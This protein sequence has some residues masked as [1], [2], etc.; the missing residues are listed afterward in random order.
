MQALGALHCL[1]ALE[2]NC[3]AGLGRAGAQAGCEPLA[4]LGQQLTALDLSRCSEAGGTVSYPA[5]AAKWSVLGRCKTFAE[6][7]SSHCGHSAASRARCARPLLMR[8]GLARLPP[9]LGALSR[10]RELN[11]NGNPLEEAVAGAEETAGEGQGAWAPLGLLGS[12][13][14]LSAQKCKLRCLPAELGQLG[15]HLLALDTSSNLLGS[16]GAG[17][18]A[19]LA[20]CRAL[21][22]LALARCGLGRLPPG[23]L[24]SLR[25]L[26]IRCNARLGQALGAERAAGE[27]SSASGAAWAPL[28]HCSGL[29]QLEAGGCGLG[30]LP[31]EPSALSALQ[32]LSLAALGDGLGA[33]SEALAPLEQLRR[34]TYVDFCDAAHRDAALPLLEAAA[35]RSGRAWA[36][37]EGRPGVLTVP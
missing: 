17:A 24:T 35:A 4:Q 29:T 21:T 16:G 25:R 32:H 7:Q 6:G 22:Q 34:L 10:L 15:R 1:K 14:S 19:P 20:C 27:G 2:A 26:S 36:G 3:N 37:V 11:L 28:W 23:L 5:P 30:A 8:A 18:L 31:G 12:L 33:S 13:T 9:A